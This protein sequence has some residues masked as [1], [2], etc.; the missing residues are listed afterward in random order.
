MKPMIGPGG[1]PMVTTGGLP[2]VGDPGCVCC[3]EGIPNC[4]LENICAGDMPSQVTV[5]LPKVT[6]TAPGRFSTN[7]GDFVLDYVTEETNI[8]R[9]GFETWGNAYYCVYLGSVIGT[10]CGK[11]VRPFAYFGDVTP[12]GT[13]PVIR[14]GYAYFETSGPP[15]TY[16]FVEAVFNAYNTYNL[17]I[18]LTWV[19]DAY[20][21]GT[22]LASNGSLSITEYEADDDAPDC[23]D[24]FNSYTQTVFTKTITL[25][26]S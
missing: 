4:N 12:V 6:N 19:L 10:E 7:G 23:D 24:E 18:A 1:L 22:C 16:Y 3:G 13:F 20:D 2:L 9:F 14:V 5:A 17:G 15:P 8:Q 25:T 11:D 21:A 26:P